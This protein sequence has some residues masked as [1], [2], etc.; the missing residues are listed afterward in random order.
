MGIVHGR[1]YT[2]HPNIRMATILENLSL[3]SACCYHGRF[4]AYPYVGLRVSSLAFQFI[5]I[6]FS[7]DGVSEAGYIGAFTGS[8]LDIVKCETNDL[9]VPA[10][11][12]IVFE[13]TLSITET[14]PEGP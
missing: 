6:S 3:G 4:Y 14:A 9:Y 5:C 10:T 8:S 7:A 13:G 1:T 2:L 11:S 12:E